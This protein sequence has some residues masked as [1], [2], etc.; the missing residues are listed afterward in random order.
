MSLAAAASPTFP[1]V[2][3]SHP[4]SVAI[5]ELGSWGII[6]GYTND[7]FGPEDPVVR[8]QFAKMI[9]KTMGV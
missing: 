7:N 4:Y 1:D 8:Q 2:P 9:V 3:S 5:T 6:I